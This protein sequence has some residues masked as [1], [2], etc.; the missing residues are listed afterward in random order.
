MEER[1]LVLLSW[2]LILFTFWIVLRVISK[3]DRIIIYFILIWFYILLFM[4]FNSII[5]YIVEY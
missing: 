1:I 2:K 3:F 5:I 4:H